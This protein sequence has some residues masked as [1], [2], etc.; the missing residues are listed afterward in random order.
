MNQPIREPISGPWE[1]VLY[2]MISGKRPFEA[3]YE[4]ALMYSI[5]NA[6]PEP[7][8][9]TPDRCPNGARTHY[10]QVPGEKP[11]RAVPTRR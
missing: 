2:E 8:T 9:G 5:L 4:N 11:E 3:E 7:I 1:F 10:Q 6:E